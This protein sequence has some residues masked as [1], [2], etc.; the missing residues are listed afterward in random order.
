MKRFF[1]WVVAAMLVSIT[2]EG[3][4]AYPFPMKAKQPD[5][6]VLTV[7]HHGDEYLNF[8]T[9]ADGYT[10]VRDSRGYLVYAKKGGD[11]SLRPTQMVAHDADARQDAEIGFLSGIQPK[12]IPAMPERVR[13]EM[14][15]EQTRR[16]RALQARRANGYDYSKFHGLIILVEYNDK[17]F[18]Y[19]NMAEVM[20]GLVNQENYK[21]TKETNYAPYNIKCYGSVHDYYKQNSGG[22]F[23]PKFDI[24]GPVQVNRSCTYVKQSE[25]AMDL[26]KDVLAVVDDQV[27]FRNYDT[28]GDGEVDMIY[29]LFAGAGSHIATNNKDL[30]WPHSSQ[31]YESYN[32]NWWTGQYTFVPITKDG[33]KLGR[34]ACSTELCAEDWRPVLDGI[35]TMCHEFSHVLGL[36]DFYDADYEK[37]G[38]ESKHPGLWSLMSGG[39][40]GNYGR[41]PVGYSLYERVFLGFAPEPTLITGEGHFSLQDLSTTNQGFRIDTPVKNEYFLLENRQQRGWDVSLPGHGMIVHRVD[42]TNKSVWN[43]NAVNN[44]PNHMYYEMLFAN[45]FH[46]LSGSTAGGSAS[47]PFPGTMKVT[48]LNNV[49]SPASLRSWAGKNCVWGLENISEQDGVISFEVLDVNVLKSI[50]LPASFQAWVG[51]SSQLVPVRTPDYAPYTLSWQSD[52]T[53]V[54]VV[55]Q[56]GYVTGISEGTALVTVTANG[57][58]TATCTIHVGRTDMVSNISELCAQS[59]DSRVLVRLTDAQVVYVNK[60]NYYVRDESGSIVMSDLDITLEKGDVLN[61]HVYLMAGKSNNI[62][63]AKPIAGVTDFSTIS[64]TKNVEVLP[65]VRQLSETSDHY[66]ANLITFKGFSIVA[67][68]IGGTNKRQVACDGERMAFLTN[69]FSVPNLK[70]P[71]TTAGKIFEVTGILGTEVL[72]GETYDAIYMLS[73]ITEADM[74]PVLSPTLSQGRIMVSAGE[75]RL[76]GFAS[77]TPVS[78]YAPDGRLVAQA[79]TLSDGT[80]SLPLRSWPSGVYLIRLEGHT[81]KFMKQ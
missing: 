14:Q 6:S 37:S 30:L 44:N 10:V 68:T 39:N 43:T 40:Y 9:T 20:E 25:N 63:C 7:C 61:G 35:G 60:G 57:S 55:G 32:Y 18:L 53:D 27:D 78:V 5:G 47:D 67:Q 64:V 12:L 62:P 28:D 21:G 34:Y 45:G 54:A 56:D 19:D 3:V 38:G 16:A 29:F 70:M 74:T 72:N 46:I 48:S 77:A 75:L 1:F 24:V 50:T 23:S 81:V 8:V 58:L 49:T 42:Q 65:I 76:S 73:K 41:T 71:S 26:M 11:G 22:I 31:L 79:R 17:S 2:A 69:P 59:E 51:V 52:N 33:I 13:I 66:Y 80:L 15:E 36:P 4:P